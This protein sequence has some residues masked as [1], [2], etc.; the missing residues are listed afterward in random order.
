M[1]CTATDGSGNV[2]SCSFEVTIIDT[3][4]PDVLCPGDIEV[5]AQSP[6]GAGVTFE[7]TALDVCDG[8]LPVSCAPLQSGDIF[9]VGLTTVTCSS[10]DASSNQGTCSFTVKV[11]SPEE[12]TVILRETML[13]LEL[14]KGTENSFEVSITHALEN[15]QEGDGAVARNQLNA[16]INKVEAQSGKKISPADAQALIALAEGILAATKLPVAAL[17]EAGRDSDGPICLE[18]RDLD[19]G[20]PWG[21]LELRWDEG[22]LQECRD[23]EGK[24]HDLSGTVSPQRIEIRGAAS[25]FFRLRLPNPAALEKRPD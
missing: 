13:E 20:L 24:W 8:V 2:S 19:E 15:L 18:I 5:D 14:H 3:T 23:V 10:M 12:M 17:R 9:P 21:M 7:S 25:R 6:S 4:P 11:R 1:N 22:I 16:F